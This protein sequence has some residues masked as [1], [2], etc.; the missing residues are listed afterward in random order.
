MSEANGMRGSH[1]NHYPQGYHQHP[2]LEAFES[3]EE[4]V[5]RRKKRDPNPDHLDEESERPIVPIVRDRTPRNDNRTSQEL[6][7][8]RPQNDHTSVNAENSKIPI[9]GN[10]GNKIGSAIERKTPR[11]KEDIAKMNLKKKTRKR[12]RRFEI[13]GVVVTTTT[14]KVIYGDE[15]NERYYDE[16]YFRKQELRELKLLQKQE[17]KQFQDLT[18]K[19]AVCREQQDK[20]FEQERGVLIRNYE[21][22]LQS[23]V[24]QQRKQV[25]RAEEQQHVDVKVTSKKIRAEQ[26]KELKSFRES[27]KTE[28]KLLKQEIELLPKDRRKEELK[29]RKEALEND[30]Q[31]RVSI[32]M[33]LHFCIVSS[34]Y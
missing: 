34:S 24:D 33:Q 16:H 10:D 19:N 9:D 2:E 8:N 3:E 20:R 30:Q 12:T 23:M 7:H 5:L 18:F 21:N 31:R 1:T 4:V 26:E 28:V 13:D 14:S 17:Q 27:L 11:T 32:L 29:H 15:E 6:H 25:D 22:D